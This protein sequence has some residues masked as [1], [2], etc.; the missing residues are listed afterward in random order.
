ML[1]AEAIP[2]GDRNAIKRDAE[3]TVK[4]KDVIIDIQRMWNVPAKM[5]PVITGASGTISE[6]FRQ[7]LTNVDREHEIK[8]VQKTTI[9]D[10][11]YILWKV[12]M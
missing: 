6:S 4:Y 2:G 3:R 10:T 8:G 11:A 9:L 7:Y 12:L 5:I 1:I